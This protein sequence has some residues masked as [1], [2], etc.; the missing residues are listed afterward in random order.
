M[1]WNSYHNKICKAMCVCKVLLLEPLPVQNIHIEFF[2]KNFIFHNYF[3]FVHRFGTLCYQTPPW[4]YFYLWGCWWPC[5]WSG[6]LWVGW[7]HYPKT[8]KANPPQTS[9]KKK[10]HLIIFLYKK[11][12]TLQYFFISKEIHNFWLSFF[13]SCMK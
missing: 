9:E 8:L 4:L 5:L 1:N 11:I 10:N 12:Y 6:W 2:L 13:Y 3:S 7:T